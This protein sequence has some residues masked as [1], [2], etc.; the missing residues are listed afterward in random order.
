M[1]QQEQVDSEAV[2][3][4]LA[5]AELVTAEGEPYRLANAWADQTAVLV[6]VRHFG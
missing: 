1:A 2:P 3:P 4:G 5:D 6:W